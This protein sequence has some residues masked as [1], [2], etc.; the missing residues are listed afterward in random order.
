M[1]R[2]VVMENV[3]LVPFKEKLRREIFLSFRKATFFIA[4]FYIL[5][6]VFFIFLVQFGQ[7]LE[8]RRTILTYFNQ[9][10]W[11]SDLIFKKLDTKEVPR[12]L[13]G[14]RSEREM[15]RHIYEETGQLPF[16]TALSLYRAD[17]SLA[18]STKLPNRDGLQDD[19]YVKIALK[20]LKKDSEYR[21]MKD[22]QGN[23][24]LLKLKPI[25]QKQQTIGYFV[26]YID[27]NDFKSN[28]SS[29]STQY[30]LTDK[31]QNLFS[32]N[33]LSFAN[34]NHHKVVIN[35]SDAILSYQDGKVYLNHQ[36]ELTPQLMLYT[37]IVAFPLSYLLFFTGLFATFIFMLHYL[38]AKHLSQKIS[39]HSSDSIELLVK[40]LDAIVNGYQSTLSITTD[41]E[42]GFLAKKINAVLDAL[43]RLFQQ[44]LTSEQE[45]VL[46][47]RKL[48]EAQF[49]PHF[50]YN[51]LESI[52]ILM[53]IDPKKAE[54][55]ILALNRVLRYSIS[56]ESDAVTLEQDMAILKD[57]LLVN[58]IRFHQLKVSLH[59]DQS[60]AQLRIPKLF[61][62]PLVE[63]ALKY[64][65]TARHDLSV[66]V[67]V[68]CQEKLICF[69]VSDNGPDFSRHFQE[70][71]DAYVKSGATE[72]GLVNS[73]SRLVMFYPS[74]KIGLSLAESKKGIQLQFER[75]QACY[76]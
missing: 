16:R 50:L 57:Y 63:N 66:A 56:T 60:L 21:I 38:L 30:I 76:E 15:F 12:F 44:T 67:E 68:T 7:L 23:R 26:L 53:Y 2:V 1:L 10:D 70:T 59:Y 61:L 46:I 37:K 19:S 3:K 64:G 28:L 49:N 18:L 24:Y 4:C 34:Q 73:Y 32:T 75:K 42:F 71:L 58:Q 54:K 13:K 39:L 55:M 47:Q 65:M 48:L 62:L 40:D 22:Y 14:E 52:K 51:S 6:L 45:K 72:H 17:G 27:G 11:Q 43:Q 36:K 9:V 74:T 41:D 5:F 20:N 69:T 33:S 25:I 31:F 29:E 35:H 8:G